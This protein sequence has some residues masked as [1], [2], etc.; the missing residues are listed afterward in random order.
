M[1]IELPPNEILREILSC[2]FVVDDDGKRRPL[3]A[4]I[5]PLHAAT[6]Y[7]AVLKFRPKQV[8]E[9]GM[10]LGISTLSILTA[11]KE[12][13]EGGRLISI[14]PLQS[15]NEKGIGVLSV[16][17]AGLSALHEVIEKPSYEALPELLAKG[18]KMDFGYIDGNHIF[19]YAL[20][21]FFYMDKMMGAGGVI[22]FNDCGWRSIHRLLKFVRTHRKYEELNVG[23]SKNYRGRNP[24]FSIL[25]WMERRSSAD[26][27][28]RKLENWEPEG[29]FFRRF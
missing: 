7:H 26:R 9:I 21:D 3:Y 13:D 17:R 10:C 25:R 8:V 6:L 23:L 12:L 29:S 15:I 27:Y 24:L 1:N 2:G 4:G 18:F 14:D 22:G 16:R 19:D 20:L 28:F 11:L 5:S